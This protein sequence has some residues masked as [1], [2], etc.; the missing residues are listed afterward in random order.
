M[1]HQEI[2]LIRVIRKVTHNASMVS[3]NAYQLNTQSKIE[4]K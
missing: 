3:Y 1:F 2:W 4:Q